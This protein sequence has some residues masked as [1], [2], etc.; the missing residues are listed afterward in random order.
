LPNEKNK[1]ALASFPRLGWRSF[2]DMLS[3]FINIFTFSSSSSREEMYSKPAFPFQAN[4]VDVT[5]QILARACRPKTSLQHSICD[6]NH[7]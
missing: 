5:I 6:A 1:A 3:A 7:V 4:F 2:I